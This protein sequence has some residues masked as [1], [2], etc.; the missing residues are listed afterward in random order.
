MYSFWVFFVRELKN[1]LIVKLRKL[2]SLLKILSYEYF[3]KVSSSSVT[4]YFSPI[5]NSCFTSFNFCQIFCDKNT[6]KFWWYR[7]I[8]K[9]ECLQITHFGYTPSRHLLFIL[10][11]LWGNER[12]HHVYHMLQRVWDELDYRIDEFNVII[13]NLCKIMK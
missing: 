11:L 12:T 7:M 5:Y 13:L 3:M 9:I 1:Q 10:P 4:H 2:V 6:H 8:Q